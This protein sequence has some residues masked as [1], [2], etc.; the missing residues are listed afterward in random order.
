MD[1]ANEDVPYHSVPGKRGVV[2]CPG[3]GA[4]I[5]PES[6]FRAIGHAAG[7]SGGVTFS[8]APAGHERW[9]IATRGSI[10]I[11]DLGVCD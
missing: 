1:L 3:C 11:F 8:P 10:F 6:A 7:K 4:A 9:R 2:S 5:G